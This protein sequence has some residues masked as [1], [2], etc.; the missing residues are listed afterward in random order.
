MSANRGQYGLPSLAAVTT[1]K[2]G[3]E[4]VA[5]RRY[6]NGVTVVDIA[7]G[8]AHLFTLT[9]SVTFAFVG[10]VPGKAC[11]ATLLLTQDAT[12]GRA[13]TWPSSVK[14]LP[15]GSAPTFTTTANTHTV[16]EMFTVDG[17]IVWFVGLA[18]TGIA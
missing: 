18:G 1:N 8:N 9:G 16:I 4:R 12:G 13:I 17:G 3:L 7:A 15:A 5:E 10:A 2:G 11:S 6:A 14:W